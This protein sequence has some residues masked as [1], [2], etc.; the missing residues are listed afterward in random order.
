MTLKE[1]SARLAERIDGDCDICPCI[2]RCTEVAYT[3]K[4]IPDCRKELYKLLK[5][6]Q[7]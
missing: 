3:K 1:K 7:V 6:V 2:K 5:E 4:G